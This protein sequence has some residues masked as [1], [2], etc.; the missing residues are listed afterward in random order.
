M[1]DIIRIKKSLENS[2]VL[3]DGVSETAK[4]EMKQQGGFLGMLLGTLGA[5][6]LENVS[7]GKGVMRAGKVL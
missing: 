3:V 1:V 7:T 2:G 4:H 5:S 6:M